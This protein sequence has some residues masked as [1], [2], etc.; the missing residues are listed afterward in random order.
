MLRTIL[1]EYNRGGRVY[2]YLG[3]V[4]IPVGEPA[5]KICPNRRSSV[6]IAAINHWLF[7]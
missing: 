4:P 7:H 6:A 5:H 2:I 3:W 1:N